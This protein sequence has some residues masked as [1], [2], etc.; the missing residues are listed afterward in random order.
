MRRT[1]SDNYFHESECN[2]GDCQRHY[3]SE[4]AHLWRDCDTAIVTKDG[5]GHVWY[6][7]RECPQC[8]EDSR[9]QRARRE[10]ERDQKDNPECPECSKCF[11]E[12]DGVAIHLTDQHGWD[13]E[14][15]RLWLR[16]AIEKKAF[17]E[18]L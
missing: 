9:R 14:K 16:D 5:A 10:I 11:K 17:N 13:Y 6:E 4:H 3:C 2:V 7:M 15:A 1:T 8:L 18:T 12:Y